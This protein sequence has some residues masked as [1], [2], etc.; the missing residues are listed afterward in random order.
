[1][2]DGDELAR[3]EA[4][5]WAEQ[6]RSHRAALVRD[7][8]AGVLTIDDLFADLAAGRGSGWGWGAGTVR[9]VVLAE[10]VPGVGKVRARRAMESMGISEDARW[11]EVGPDRLRALWLEMAEA[12]TRTI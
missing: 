4:F 9:V 2:T 7:V 12:A 6:M 11:G 1:M 5:A 8:G 3:D 10:S